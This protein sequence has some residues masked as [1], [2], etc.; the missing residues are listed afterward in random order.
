MATFAQEASPQLALQMA[1]ERYIR[2][3]TPVPD[4]HFDDVD[5][6]KTIDLET[7]VAIR[8]PG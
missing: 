3:A 4:G 7:R 5:A 8:P 2:E 6:S 1:H